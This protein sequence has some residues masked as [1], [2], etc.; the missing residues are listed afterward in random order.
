MAV[1]MT[2]YADILVIVNLYVDYIL[3]SCVRGFLRLKTRGL[4]LVL[5]ALAGA[6]ISLTGLLDLPAWTGP[7]L[8][9]ACAFAAAAAAFAP[10]KPRLLVRCWLSTWAFSFLLAGFL[11]FAMQFAPPGY[12]ALV[13]GAVYLNL[14]LPVLFFATCGA[15]GVFWLAGKLLPR[16]HG[17]PL[18][19]LTVERQGCTAVLFAKADTGNALR[20]PFSGLPVVVCQRDALAS[21][22]PLPG[23]EDLSPGLRLVPFESLGGKGLLAAFRP[24]KATL[25][26]CAQPLDCYI[27]VTDAALSAGQFAALYNPELFPALELSKHKEESL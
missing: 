25:A 1:S 10:A 2:I 21:L 3:L 20:E 26:G 22:G 5:G 6:L 9:G 16:D 8:G 18:A 23:P 11:L 4:R 24:D 19:K 15:Y 27:A 17:P 13:G 12:M 7:I 14:S